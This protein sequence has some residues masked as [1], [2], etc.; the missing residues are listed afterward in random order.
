MAERAVVDTGIIVSALAFGGTPRA[1]LRELI[2]RSVLFVSPALLDEYRAV[3]GEL[4]A[5]RKITQ[6][7]RPSSSP[8]RGPSSRALGQFASRSGSGL[9]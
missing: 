3:P 1:A 2:G 5:A 4:L 8:G 7:Q 6:E 9:P